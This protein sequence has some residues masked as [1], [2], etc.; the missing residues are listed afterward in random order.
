M[1]TAKP[2]LN[3]RSAREYFREH[4]SVGDYYS[5]GQKV[6]GEWFGQGA[7]KLGLKGTV[8]EA[9]FLALCEGKNPANGSRLT[10][11]MNSKRRDEDGKV[12]ANRRVFYDLTLSPP[13]S[14]SV[15][16]LLQDER[17]LAAHDKAVRHAMEELEKLAQ[18]RVRKGGEHGER[19]TGNVVA[20]AFRHDT[21]RELDPHLHTHCVVFN[22]TFDGTENRW[23]A[24]EVQG[25]YRAQRFAEKVDPA[26]VSFVLAGKKAHQ[27][28]FAGAVGA[29]DGP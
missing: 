21:S 18:A 15:V 26:L 2:Q 5:A 8:K 9:E 11:R 4:L 29:H 7:E 6:T 20:A 12:V 23:K 24:L 19:E 27:R 17:I 14:V 22:A 16:A 10:A 13:K 3:L 28:R 1:L 25:M